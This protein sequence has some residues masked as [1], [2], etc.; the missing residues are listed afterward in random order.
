[1]KRRFSEHRNVHYVT[2][3]RLFDSSSPTQKSEHQIR[4]EFT[5]EKIRQHV[6]LNVQ[7]QLAA[8]VKS[9]LFGESQKILLQPCF[10]FDNYGAVDENQSKH[11]NAFN[12]NVEQKKR[13]KKSVSLGSIRTRGGQS[14]EPAGLAYQQEKYGL[15]DQLR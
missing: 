12:N 7:D 4:Y 15:K 5:P 11:S 10:D 14:K 6:L 2:N 9:R 13:M 1:M 3:A 8:G